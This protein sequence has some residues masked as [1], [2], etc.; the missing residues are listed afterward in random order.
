[1]NV[2]V[3]ERA[4]RELLVA[5]VYYDEQR[6]FLGDDFVQEFESTVDRIV[7]NPN[8]WS[9]HGDHARICRLHRFP[10]GVIYHVLDDEVLI[11][12]VENL[13]RDPDFWTG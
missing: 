13:R 2:V 11:V 4:R 8:A 1:M 10:Y 6:L 3:S 7:R 5:S 9:R 12:S